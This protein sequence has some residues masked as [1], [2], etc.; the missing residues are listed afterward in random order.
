MTDNPKDKRRFERYAVRWKIRFSS[1]ELSCE[2][3]TADVSQSGASF[4]CDVALPSSI[5]STVTLHLPPSS[6][7][8]KGHEMSMHA[9][10]IY[11]ILQGKAGFRIGLQFTHIDDKNAA[12]LAKKLEHL[13]AM[14]SEFR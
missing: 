12:I 9:R 2:T 7:H 14:N 3:R 5:K 4:H 10:V 8:P 11:C 1:S 13:D 6:Q